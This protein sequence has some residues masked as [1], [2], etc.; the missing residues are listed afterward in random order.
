MFMEINRS[1]PIK[2]KNTLIVGIKSGGNCEAMINSEGYNISNDGTCHLTAAGD[3]IVTDITL[4]QL[5]YNGGP[6]STYA[7]PAGSPAVNGGNPVGCT[8]QNGAAIL[9]DQRGRTR[10]WK[11]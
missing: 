4:N 3:Q 11:M 10:Q 7:L 8:D 9:T 6:A 2:I 5:K 1:N